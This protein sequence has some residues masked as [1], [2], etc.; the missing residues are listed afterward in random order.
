MMSPK[1]HNNDKKNVS[2]KL[3]E[4]LDNANYIHVFREGNGRAQ[5]EFLRLLAFEKDLNL[6]STQQTIKV[7][8][9][10]F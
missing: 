4:I 5:R 9:K 3:A 7:F 2:E 6:M 10:A 1:I 8:I